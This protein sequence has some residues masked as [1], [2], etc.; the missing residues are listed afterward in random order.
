M[1]RERKTRNRTGSAYDPIVALLVQNGV[2][3]LESPE[4]GRRVANYAKELGLKVKLDH[5][6][7]T[8]ITLL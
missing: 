4:K 6:P 5:K 8:R 1:K 7:E 2:V 3:T